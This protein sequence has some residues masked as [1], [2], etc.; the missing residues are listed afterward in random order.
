MLKISF[1]TQFNPE[2]TLPLQSNFLKVMATIVFQFEDKNI[3]SKTYSI[4]NG[5]SVLDIA[6]E[7][8]IG[9]H[10]NCGGVCGCSTC[11]IYVVDGM[12][13]FQEISDR[14]EDFIDR[15]I[16]PKINS[17]LACQCLLKSDTD[18]IVMVP[19]QTALNGH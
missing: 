2:F 3:A 1:S 16:N 4:T 19:D 12:D 18:V 8:D 11:H 13:H 7:E 15:A 9:L 5:E 17:R 10:H 14:E 6:M